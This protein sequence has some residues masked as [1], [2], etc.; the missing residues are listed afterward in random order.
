MFK[1]KKLS[2]LT[3]TIFFAL[4]SVVFAQE[5]TSTQDSTTEV[6]QEINLDENVTP[7]DL[8][9]SEPKI[10]PDSPFYFLKNWGRAIR[11]FFA[12][13]PIDKAKLRLRFASE[14]LLEAKKLAEKTKNP[15]IIKRVT[16][17]YE[18]EIDKIK[19]VADRIKEKA[20]ENLEVG[21]FLDKFTKHQILHE[22]ILE[23]L[24]EQVPPEVFEKIKEARERHLQRFGEVMQKLEEN[25]EKVRERIEK[26]MEKIKGSRFKDFKNL[27]ILKKLEEKVPEEGK[28]A[29]QKARERILERLEEKIQQMTTTTQEKLKRYIEKIQ[30]DPEK[31]LEILEDIKLRL[32]NQLRIRERLENAGEEIMQKIKEKIQEK[33][34]GLKCPQWVPPAPGFCKEGRIVIEKNEKGCPLPPKCII[35]GETELP[36]SPTTEPEK[37]VCISL[38]NPVCG[39]DGK[40]Y[41]N[42]CW[43]RV[44]GVEIL[45]K[46]VCQES[47]PQKLQRRIQKFEQRLK[48]E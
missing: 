21:K 19:E 47:L 15:E 12:F 43:A 44:A 41:S 1:P 35:P 42:S 28:E 39:K 14:K 11:S 13:R 22:K 40:T 48:G 31:K 2:I 38:W 29:I 17:N 9:V 4:T 26:N 6:A 23:K 37:P 5:T 16:E 30:G 8:E 24:Q 20:S 33:E 32:K 36:Q 7:Q 18:R 46:G 45:H 34:V 3:V 25:W 10:L 27:E